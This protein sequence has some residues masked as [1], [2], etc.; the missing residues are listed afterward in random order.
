MR[1]KKLFR[2]KWFYCFIIYVTNKCNLHCENCAAFSNL[3]ITPDSP[4]EMMRESYEIP[5]SEV[6]ELC[7]RLKGYG[8]K[9]YVKLTGGEPTVVKRERFEEIIDVLHF[10]NRRIWLI[11]NGY[12][13][14]D[15]SESTLRK[16]DKYTVDDH[17]IN[18]SHV[19]Q[20]IKKLKKI[21][22]RTIKLLSN[23]THRDCLIASRDKKDGKDCGVFMTT[24]MLYKRTVYPCCGTAFIESILDTRDA[25]TGLK[26]IG[27]TLDNP[28]LVEDMAKWRKTLPP[29]IYDMCYNHCWRPH[30]KH[31]PPIPITLKPNDVIHR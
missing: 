8:E 21:G 17:G 23:T 10:Y 22:G 6:E 26:E 24:P 5:V 25:T 1:L 16:I 15:T 30:F 2:V 12:G 13:V 7:L 19:I 29:V 31:Y 20:V 27:W 4:Y 3:P 28:N 9:E 18:H 11:T 14:L